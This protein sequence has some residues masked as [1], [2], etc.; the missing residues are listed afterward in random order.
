MF[1][2]QCGATQPDKLNFCKTC[3]ANLGAVRT[4]LV[5]DPKSEKFDWSKTWVAEMM[6]SSKESVRRAA[7]LDRLRGI[8]PETKR[9]KEIKAGVITAASGLGLTVVLS[10]IMEAIVINGH[11]TPLAADICSRVWIVGLIPIL[12]GLALIINGTFISTRGKGE[13]E[14]TS[15]SDD[16]NSLDFAETNR[17]PEAVPFSVIDETTRHLEKVPAGKKTAEIEK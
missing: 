4:A 1:C 5:T 7:E 14:S 8:T 13:D 6:L 11:L 15:S 2:P 3:G 9:R 17:L 12:V 16:P 10:V